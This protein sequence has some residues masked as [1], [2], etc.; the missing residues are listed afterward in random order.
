MRETCIWIPCF[1]FV[2]EWMNFVKKKKKKKKK[3][4]QLK[5]NEQNV[6]QCEPMFHCVKVTNHMNCLPLML[7]PGV[8]MRI[9]WLLSYLAL[10]IV[11][12]VYVKVS[13]YTQYLLIKSLKNGKVGVHQNHYDSRA[14]AQDR[15]ATEHSL[16]FPWQFTDIAIIFLDVIHQYFN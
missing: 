12:H 5:I 14:L 9:Y 6:N 13:Y 16:T 10:T 1:C 7:P 11:L 3:N 8:K 4:T 2:Y 15:V